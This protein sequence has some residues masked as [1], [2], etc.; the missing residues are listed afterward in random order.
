MKF[1]KYIF[2]PVSLWFFG[3]VVCAQG[4]EFGLKGGF[5]LGTPYGKPVEGARGSPGL[6]PSAGF[7]VISKLNLQW[8]I[9]AEFLISR[10]SSSF[11]TPVSG[12]TIWEDTETNPGHTYYWPTIYRGWVTGEFNNTYLDIPVMLSYLLSDKWNLLGG[13]QFSYLL[14]GGNSGTADIEVGDP[15]SPFTHVEDEPFDQSEELNQWDYGIIIGSKYQINERFNL[16]TSLSVGLISIYNK[17]YKYL[18]KT[19]RNIYL[20]LS[21]GFDLGKQ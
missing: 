12:D 4:L 18:D 14:K 17:N 6:A 2:L 7:Y 3:N 5:N 19:Y 13:I 15:E 11:K 20:Q 9:Q 10:K 1:I 16:G 8:R 21:M